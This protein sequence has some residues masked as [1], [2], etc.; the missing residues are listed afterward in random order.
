MEPAQFENYVISLM[1]YI[2]MEYEGA[3]ETV[4]R[5][6]HE[7]FM[8]SFLSFE[9]LPNAAGKFAEKFLLQES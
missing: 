1:T 8:A 6:M 2:S 7:F 3:P 4:T 5:E 9:C